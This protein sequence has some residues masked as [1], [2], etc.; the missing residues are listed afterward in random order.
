MP[1]VL[2][3]GEVMA[4]ALVFG[5]PRIGDCDGEEIEIGV[6]VGIEVIFFVNIYPPDP[7]KVKKIITIAINFHLFLGTGISS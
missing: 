4:D 2:S 3:G 7:T 5:T 1:S 6:G